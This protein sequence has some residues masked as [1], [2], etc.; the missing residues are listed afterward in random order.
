M[1]L[2]SS[3]QKGAVRPASAGPITRTKKLP[4]L[5]A[6]DSSELLTDAHN[7]AAANLLTVE[8]QHCTP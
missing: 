8:L 4:R 6:H 5:L 2:T 3:L 7:A 1:V